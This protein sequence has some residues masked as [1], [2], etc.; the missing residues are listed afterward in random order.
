M[1]G[2][3]FLLGQTGNAPHK[4]VGHTPLGLVILF[5]NRLQVLTPLSCNS[6]HRGILMSAVILM[7]H[8][9]TLFVNLSTE[10]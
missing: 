5:K 7:T 2:A 9:A 10:G 6:R 8:G 1:S 4:L 3:I